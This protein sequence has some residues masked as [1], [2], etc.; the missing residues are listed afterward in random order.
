LQNA[1]QIALQNADREANRK[2]RDVAPQNGEKC[3]KWQNS[4][5]GKIRVAKNANL[6]KSLLTMSQ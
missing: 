3:E 6:R 4:P 1:R 2:M 5:F